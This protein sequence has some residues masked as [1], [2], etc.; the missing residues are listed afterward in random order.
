MNPPDA[1]SVFAFA[2]VVTACTWL[3]TAVARWGDR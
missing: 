3:L 1:L 2:C